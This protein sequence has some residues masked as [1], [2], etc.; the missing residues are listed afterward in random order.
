MTLP[1][2]PACGKETVEGQ[3]FC[4]SCGSRLAASPPSQPLRPSAAVKR[5]HRGRN[6]AVVA[7][8]VILV[9]VVGVVGLASLPKSNSAV[10]YT[11]Q[12][13]GMAFTIGP[14]QSSDI[15]FG[16]PPATQAGQTISYTLTG[17]FTATGLITAYFMNY[18]SFTS[19]ALGTSYIYASGN[20][21]SGTIDL[22][23]VPV[24]NA[25]YLVFYNPS[26]TAN[27]TVT[28]TQ[29]LVAKGTPQS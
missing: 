20:V 13:S 15:A 25:Y 2:C 1:L 4:P 10:T 7:V 26:P 14:E 28:L 5:S 19:F 21:T 11:M 6:L 18:T 29:P 16:L 23:G 9:L 27:C 17:S 3:E 8:V 24:A 12:S 22:N